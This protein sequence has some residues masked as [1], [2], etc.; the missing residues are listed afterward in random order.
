M[1]AQI[2]EERGYIDDAATVT[3]A[4]VATLTD[5]SVEY[6]LSDGPDLTSLKGLEQF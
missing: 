2:L 1:F 3:P 6:G 5:V 4:D